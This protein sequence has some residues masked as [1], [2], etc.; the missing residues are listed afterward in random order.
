LDHFD[1]LP[2]IAV[3]SIF[4]FTEKAFRAFESDYTAAGSNAAIKRK[5][6]NTWAHEAA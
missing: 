5:G 4:I 2:L 1:N 3:L 6:R